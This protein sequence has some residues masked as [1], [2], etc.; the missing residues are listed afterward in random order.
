[1][2]FDL[3]TA[4]LT[5][6]CRP[7][8]AAAIFTM[9]MVVTFCTGIVIVNNLRQALVMDKKIVA[10][11]YILHGTFVIDILATAALWASVSR[12]NY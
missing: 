11:H 1:M 2:S 6:D 8:I 7:V 10:K 4:A 5:R 12:P 9:D 3:R